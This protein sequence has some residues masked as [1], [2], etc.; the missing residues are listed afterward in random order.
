M[1]AEMPALAAP[2]LLRQFVTGIGWATAATV[3]ERA[4]GLLQAILIAHFLGIEDY[5]RYGLLFVTAGWISSVAGLQLGLTTTVMVAR[6][7]DSDPMR[8][9]AVIRLSEILTVA[10]VL[11]VAAVIWSCPA[12]LGALL[13]RGQGYGGVM[14][15][16]GVMA[17]LGVLTGIQD[18]VVQGYENFKALAI[19]RTAGAVAGLVLVVALGRAGGLGAVMLALML[20]L[21][22]RF[23][24]VLTVKEL[25]LRRHKVLLTWRQILDVRDVLWSFSL[26][27]ML[28]SAVTGA[29]AWYGAVL[30]TDV[31]DG[32][33]N[34]AV[35]TVANQWRGM[36]LLAT[37]MLS[38]VAVPMMT[39]LGEE[40]DTAA[41]SQLQGY[42]IRANFVI[43]SVAIM[44]LCAASQLVLGAYGSDFRQGWLVFSILVASTL[45][46][47]QTLVYMQYIVSQGWM[48]TQLWYLSASSLALLFAYIIAV[49]LAGVIGFAIATLVISMATTVAFGWLVKRLQVAASDDGLSRDGKCLLDCAR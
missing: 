44:L 33:Q 5:G 18:C 41:I 39:R 7:R 49:R 20:G 32:F 43:N 38:T 15:I 27:S 6:H 46:H 10:T 47:S 37:S 30:L 23:G 29:V 45:P 2:M 8:A 35:L 26:P 3:G 25:R 16:A 34:V 40:G 4:V 24:L 42:S 22:F 19:V 17:A 9:C 11:I 48:W 31:K 12:A 13:L 14:A 1:T 36:L 28:A 21:A